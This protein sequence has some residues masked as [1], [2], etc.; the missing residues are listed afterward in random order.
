MTAGKN[1]SERLPPIHGRSASVAAVAMKTEATAVTYAASRWRRRGTT[2]TLIQPR[3]GRAIIPPMTK[4][5]LAC[6]VALSWL[7]PAMTAQQAKKR[8]PWGDPD[9][10]GNYTNLYEAGTPLERPAQF[11]GKRLGDVTP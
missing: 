1:S 4:K 3:M 8:T 10:S 2:P 7:S 9:L 5:F 6:L 11:D